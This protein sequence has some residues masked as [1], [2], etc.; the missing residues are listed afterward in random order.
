M[1][2]EYKIKLITWRGKHGDVHVIAHDVKEEGRAWLYLFKLMD[3][4]G[5]YSHDLDGDEQAA[6]E[7]AK[8]GSAKGAAWLLLIRSDM[9]AE[10]EG[11][12][13]DYPKVPE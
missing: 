5:F 11:I 2:T 10:Y 12:E 8:K 6:Y 3:E 4:N 13:V 9:G 1:A 7:A